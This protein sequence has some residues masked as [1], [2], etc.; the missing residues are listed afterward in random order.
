MNPDQTLSHDEVAV[1][2]DDTIH[3]LSVL[4]ARDHDTNAAAELAAVVS[5]IGQART[6]LPDL[7]ADARDQDNSWAAIADLLHLTRPG[8]MA[9]YGHHT[10]TRPQPPDPD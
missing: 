8:A 2:V 3:A 4:F 1:V 6:R 10:R 7:V 9:R 5:L